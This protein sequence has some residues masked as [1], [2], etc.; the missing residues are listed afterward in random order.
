MSK[1]R[2]SVLREEEIRPEHLKADQAALLAADIKGLLRYK[3]KFV[4]VACPACDTKKAVRLF[5]KYGLDYCRC[6][7][8]E[9]VYVN[10][11]PTPE[12]LET[13]YSTSKNYE[14]WNKYI[15]PASEGARRTKIFRPRVER[16]ISLCRRYGVRPKT[17]VEVGAGFGTFCEEMIKKGFFGRVIAVEPTPDLARTCRRRGIE[18]IAKPVEDVEFKGMR[19]DVVASFEVIEHLFRPKDFIKSCTSL[20]SK[21]GLV[22]LTCPNVKGFDVGVLGKL[23]GTFDNEHLNYFHPGSLGNLMERYGFKVVEIATPGRLDA[24]LVRRAALEKRVDL[25]KRPFLKK[26]LIDEWEGTGADFQQFLADNLLSSHMWVVG[27]KR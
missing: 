4:C 22:V 17:L 26:I 25:S 8:C 27:R 11:R 10:P 20:V 14:Y 7:S 5:K 16:L 2:S 24:E 3:A 23:S 15:F 6:L 9:T 12:I 13:Y 19:A 1:L 21:N 18:V